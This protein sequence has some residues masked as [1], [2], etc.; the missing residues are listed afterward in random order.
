VLKK[1]SEESRAKGVSLWFSDIR[2]NDDHLFADYFEPEG[3]YQVRVGGN[4]PEGSLLNRNECKL[5]SLGVT[6]DA[7]ELLMEV[8]KLTWDLDEF[9]R[10]AGGFAPTLVLIELKNGTERGGVAAVPWPD[11][12]VTAGDPTGGSFI[13]SLGAIPA[14]FN[15]VEREAAVRFCR[16]GFMFGAR[17][18][19][20]MWNGG[21]GCGSDG[22]LDYAGPR[23]RGELIGGNAAMHRQPY[24]RW[25]L[26]RL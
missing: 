5:R 25:E 8:H 7:P 26:W 12:G 13:F 3:I 17:E 16:F 24:V 14:R 22:Q 1:A 6:L 23:E 9:Q 19:L 11:T 18:D 20:F 21:R 2:L 10:K 15:L 4:W